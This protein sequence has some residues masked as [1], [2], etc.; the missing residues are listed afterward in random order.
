[1][2][3]INFVPTKLH[4]PGE[5]AVPC[6][7]QATALGVFTAP[8]AFTSGAPHPRLREQENLSAHSWRNASNVALPA[9]SRQ[10]G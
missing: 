10:A 6:G 5:F 9:C 8:R 3:D 1:M 7:S 2:T 4:Q